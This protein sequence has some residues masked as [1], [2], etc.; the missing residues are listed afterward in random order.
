MHR[1]PVKFRRAMQLFL[2]DV[3]NFAN[4]WSKLA[5]WVVFL[6]HCAP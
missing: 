6:Y 2:I 1:A 3:D 4:S 5:S